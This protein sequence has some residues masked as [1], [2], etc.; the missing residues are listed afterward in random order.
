[1]V[2]EAVAAAAGGTA[3][4]R[5]GLVKL[6]DGKSC[7][8]GTCQWP[9]EGPCWRAPSFKG[10]LPAPQCYNERLVDKL[11]KDKKAN[12]GKP[13]VKGAL[14]LLKVQAKP[15]NAAV[16]AAGDADDNDNSGG[17]DSFFFSPACPAVPAVCLKCDAGEDVEFAQPLSAEG[18]VQAFAASEAAEGVQDQLACQE[19]LDDDNLQLRAELDAAQAAQPDDAAQQ[20]QAA[21]ED[22]MAASTAASGCLNHIEVGQV[23][24]VVGSGWDDEY[25]WPPAPRDDEATTS[26]LDEH[27]RPAVSPK[28]ERGGKAKAADEAAADKAPDLVQMAMQAWY[29]GAVFV[30]GVNPDPM[31]QYFYAQFVANYHAKHTAAA[32]PAATPPPPVP[33]DVPNANTVSPKVESPDADSPLA[34]S[35]AIPT[36]SEDVKLTLTRIFDEEIEHAIQQGMR[37]VVVQRKAREYFREIESGFY[38]GPPGST[39]HLMALGQIRGSLRYRLSLLQDY[40]AVHLGSQKIVQPGSPQLATTPPEASRPVEAS[41]PHRSPPRVRTWEQQQQ[42]STVSGLAV[43]LQESSQSSPAMPP[44]EP[45]AIPSGCAPAPEALAY[46]SGEPIA[47]ALRAGSAAQSVRTGEAGGSTVDKTPAF[48]MFKQVNQDDLGSTRDDPPDP[49]DVPPQGLI[50][51]GANIPRVSTSAILPDAANDPRVHNDCVT[52]SSLIGSGVTD[53]Q[54]SEQFTLEQGSTAATPYA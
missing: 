47:K 12:V 22:R 46:E 49:N 44:F 32:T 53:E 18:I 29:N 14:V 28:R 27:C 35:S 34:V 26:D 54:A 50:D 45:D 52:T 4:K 42:V 48:V 6:P 51:S 1:M 21:L 25:N 8:E 39:D 16:P 15:G 30:P 40:G 33:S 5:L 19:Q 17:V 31:P 20:E 24:S 7:P 43:A 2:A 41:R 3:S 37:Y 9:H 11:N 13:G 38:L 36:M 10:P 23:G